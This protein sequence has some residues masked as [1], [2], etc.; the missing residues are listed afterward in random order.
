MP[1][2]SRPGVEIPQSL[3]EPP[4]AG[5]LRPLAASR[6]RFRYRLTCRPWC[7]YLSF[8]HR[9]M[10]RPGFRISRLRQAR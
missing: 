7:R 10:T 8:Y 2:L 5:P 6:I 9:S 3:A 4:S 1:D